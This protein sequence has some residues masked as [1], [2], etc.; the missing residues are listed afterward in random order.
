MKAKKNVPVK[1]DF[2]WTKKLVRVKD[3][4]KIMNEQVQVVRNATLSLQKM[5]WKIMSRK[6]RSGKMSKKR[7]TF[8]LVHFISSSVTTVYESS[9][10]LYGWKWQYSTHT[11][12]ECLLNEKKSWTYTE[13]KLCHDNDADDEN[14]VNSLCKR[15]HTHT[16]IVQKHFYRKNVL[17]RV[18]VWCIFHSFFLLCFGA[19]CEACGCV[20]R[21]SNIH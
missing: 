7:K 19:A 8:A 1:D 14:W 5:E 9:S 21:E 13:V 10:S 18:S 2:I 17:S 16:H 11:N 4:K 3:K 20:R 12:T 15:P 6:K